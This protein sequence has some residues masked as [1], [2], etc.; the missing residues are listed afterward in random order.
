MKKLL[1]GLS[2]AILFPI[3]A[4]A[5]VTLWQEGTHYTVIAEKATSKPIVQEYFSFWCPACFNFEPLM[6]EL[7][8]NLDDGVKFDKIHVNFMPH[9]SQEN[10]NA[11]TKA[12]MIARQ[13]KQADK[14]NE[15]IFN[16]IHVQNQGRNIKSIDDFK[17]LFVVNGVDKAA[18]EKLEKNFGVTSLFNRNNKELEKNRKHVTGVPNVIV[19]GKYQVKGGVNS[20][21]EYI[22][23]VNWLAKQK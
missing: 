2:V 23:L 11:A 19:N 6:K 22:E 14:L 20:K 16:Y 21:E 5:Q 7:K 18:F 4:L 17:S 3:Q 10:Q 9:T 1:L 8:S 15:A 12:M 13:L